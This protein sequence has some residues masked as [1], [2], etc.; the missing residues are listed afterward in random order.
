MGTIFLIAVLELPTEAERIEGK[1][2]QIVVAPQFILADDIRSASNK[3]TLLAAK[4][5]ASL[6]PDRVEVLAVAPF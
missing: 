4:A 2:K 1:R 5:N 6:D 3:A